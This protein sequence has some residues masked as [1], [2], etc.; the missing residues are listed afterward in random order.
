MSQVHVLILAAGNST[1]LKS[2]LTKVLHPVCGRPMI[3]YVL[4]GARSVRPQKIC[5]VVGNGREEIQE[6]LRDQKGLIFAHQKERLGTAHAVQTG[7]KALGKIRGPV[8]I[9]T[10]DAPCLQ[11]FTLKQLLNAQPQAPL[12]LLTAVLP[13]P[14]GYG[15]ILRNLEGRIYG[16]VEEKNAS[17]EQR[18]FNEINAGFYRADAEFL[19]KTLPKI[20]K[21][22]LKGEYY[23]T[24]LVAL[25]VEQ[26]LP[27]ESLTVE[28]LH[29]VLGANTRAELAYLHQILQ[30]EIVRR[31]LDQGVGMQ[32]P[33]SLIID[34]GVKIG[35]DSYLGS[36][37]QLLGKTRVGKA[38]QIEAACILKNAVLG[39]EV[40]V[41]AFS[42][43]ED[44]E[45]RSQAVIGPFARLRPGT[46]V[47]EQAHVGNFVELKKTRLGKGSK[48]NHLSYLGDA[49]IGKGVNIGAGTITC[50]YD[51]KHKYT[52]HLGD[53]VFVGSNTQFVAP[54][55]VGKKAYIG[56]GTTVTKNVPPG[57]LAISRVPQENIKGYKKR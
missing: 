13:N 16:I 25:A 52:T 9:L 43:F 51:G 40:Q 17:P 15:R 5:L 28:D 50:N 48:A 53:G 29:E 22:P 21:D 2:R 19:R 30:T 35:A 54:V 12:A 6:H 36:G 10:G 47:E 55:K 46:T 8:L 42:Y 20:R 33:D 23:L 57:A 24:D 1:R 7:L 44:C 49:V 27:V 37:V 14:Q 34:H 38:C 11:A 32:N 45:V 26:N 31:H 3:D 39:E 41:K 18:Q 56:A 4:D